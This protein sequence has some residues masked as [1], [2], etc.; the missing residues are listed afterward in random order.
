MQAHAADMELKLA[1]SEE[2]GRKA[3]AELGGLRAKLAQADSS[4]KV[5]VTS[6]MVVVTSCVAFSQQGGI[7][8][9]I[10]C[11]VL[12]FHESTACHTPSTLCTSLPKHDLSCMA[13]VM[14]LSP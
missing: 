5:R 14:W 3:E 11:I 8:C 4:A 9:R 7:S 2:S 12:C 6:H 13:H 10:S 1:E